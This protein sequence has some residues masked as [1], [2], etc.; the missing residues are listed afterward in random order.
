MKKKILVVAAVAFYSTLQAQNETNNLDEVVIT[1]TKKEQKQSQTG[2]VVTVIDQAA[3]QRNIGKSL[4]E[5]LNQYAGVFTVGA[6]GAPGSNQELYLR[7]AATGNTLLLLDGVPLQDP[8]MISNTYDL[9]NIQPDQIERIEI[10]KGAQSTIWG[11]AAVAGVINI[12]TK[13]SGTKNISPSANLAY[14]TYNTLKAGVGLNGKIS[15]FQYNLMYN[16]IS[17]DGFS[18]ANDAQGGKGFDED[19]MKQNAF[20]AN[21]GYRFSPAFSANFISNYGYFKA[22]ADAGAGQDDFDVKSKVKNFVN[23][24][25]LSYKSEKT[26]IHLV[27]S[28]IRSDRFF[29]NDST[30]IGPLRLNPQASFYTIWSENDLRGRSVI[31]DLYGNYNFSDQISI[32][33]G[34]Q[35]TAQKTNQ[36]FESISNFGPFDA[37]P[38]HNDSA[39]VRNFSGYASALFSNLSGFNLELGGRVN[40]NSLYGNNATFTLNPSYNFSDNIRA[41]LNIS[42]G[43]N[44]PSLYQLYSEAGNR[45]LKPEKSM[46]YEI[47]VQALSSDKNSSIRLVG[48]K[49][50]IKDLITY[51]SDPV[52]YAS[53]YINRDQQNDYGVELESNLKIA[54][55]GHWINNITYIEGEGENDGVKVKNLYRRPK[56]AWNSAV[57]LNLVK[58]FKLTPSVRVVGKR[59]PGTY[60]VG[61]DP[62]KSYYTLNCNLA[63]TLVSKVKLFADFSNITNQKYF[64]AYGYNTRGFNLLAGVNLSL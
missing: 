34:L 31:T 12:I 57:E 23:S 14:G 63:Y 43:Y 32:V 45:D 9:N 4:T 49:R 61:P 28:F 22:D 20:Q 33:A 18:A 16:R 52:T 40:H 2:K 42:S 38:I 44:V 54:K 56:L 25:H 21:I 6:N 48:F 62:M 64:D 55:L 15:G 19:G 39:K 29:S 13:K 3:L 24:V 35:H 41:F 30:D 59:T 58:S 11:S 1:A 51:Y 53:Q 50:D 46:N 17:T 60:D 47:G 27:Q 5:I 26:A 8:N 7:G 37:V 10:L 36:T